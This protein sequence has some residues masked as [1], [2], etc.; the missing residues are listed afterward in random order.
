MRALFCLA[1]TP[2][3]LAAC[4]GESK[5]EERSDAPPSMPLG[6]ELAA[7]ENAPVIGEE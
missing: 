3:A 5:Q 1:I 6:Y 7:I 4:A 2:F